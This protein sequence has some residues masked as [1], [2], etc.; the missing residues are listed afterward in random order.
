MKFLEKIL[1]A[2]DLSKAAENAVQ[3]ALFVAKTFD[4]EIDL[5]HVIPEVED[6]PLGLDVLEAAATE[7]LQKIRDDI[8]AGGVQVKHVVVKSGTPFAHIVQQA[9][10]RN[11]NVI[12]MGSGQKT[13]REKFRLG[14][15]AERVVRRGDKPVWLVKPG[16]APP[17][18]KI[19]CPVDF[20]ESSKRALRNAIHLARRFKAELVVL[21]II[22]PLKDIFLELRREAV[23]RRA[24]EEYAEKKQE[25]FDRFLKDFDFH[26]VNWSKMI[27]PGKADREILRFARESGCDLIVMG[28]T[29]LTG[30]PRILMGSVAEK[31]I[32]EMPCSMVAVKSE[33]PVRLRLETEMTRI[34]SRFE[35]GKELLEQGFPE[36]A[37]GQFQHCVTQDR[38]YAPAWEALAAAHERLGHKDEATRCRTRAKEARQELWTRQVEAEIRSQHVLWGKG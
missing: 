1:V 36:D 18:K 33:D 11:V 35:Q 17:V 7:K 30:Q 5:I 38:L 14:I 4:A 27:A 19:V 16:S 32:R 10:L 25:H 29:G 20:S 26:N 12:V 34:E 37:I 2:T 28:S 9:E 8:V 31:V 15:T 23:Q 3:T 24:Q 22:Q 13:S 21:T 6:S